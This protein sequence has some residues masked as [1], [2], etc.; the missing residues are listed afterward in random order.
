L[1]IITK[2]AWKYMV[3]YFRVTRSG[4]DKEVV[5]GKKD[6]PGKIK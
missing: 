3:V 2:I 1:N 6:G 5:R 4:I